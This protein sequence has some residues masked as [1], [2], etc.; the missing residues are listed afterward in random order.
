MTVLDKLVDEL[1]AARGPIRSRDLAN[2]IGV[3]E[4]SLD[5]MVDALVS[6]GVL[7]GSAAPSPD[8]T[9][10]CSGVACGTTCVGLDECP[11]IVNVPETYALV[12]DRAVPLSEPSQQ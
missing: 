7:S 1:R 12:I 11:F 2:R 8:E 6:K 5:M 10:A 4:D 3:S 9:I